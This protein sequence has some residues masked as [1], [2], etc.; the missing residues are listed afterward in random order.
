MGI[1]N[2]PE[3]ESFH[4]LPK[5]VIVKGGISGSPDSESSELSGLVI[6]NLGQPIRQ[7]RVNLILFDKNEIPVF[8]T[9][10]E[11]NPTD[12][13]Q[14]GMASFRFLITGF[15]DSMSNYYLYPTWRFDDSGWD[16]D[17]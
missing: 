8:N 16:Q 5:Q 3:M 13:T 12:L 2:F 7:L 17:E 14:G 15:Q 11:P 10:V 9:S 6:N 1:E 4:N